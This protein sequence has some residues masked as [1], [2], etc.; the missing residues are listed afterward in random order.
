[1]TD[2]LANFPQR[3]AIG[4]F[5]YGGKRQL[6]QMTPEFFRAF[7]SVILSINGIESGAA[8]D[9]F[10]DVF[11]PYVTEP[12]SVPEMELQR[13]IDIGP[14][15]DVIFQPPSDMPSGVFTI[16][17]A[18]GSTYYASG[19]CGVVVSGGVVS[20]ISHVRG[21]VTTNLGVVSGIFELSDGDGLIITYSVAPTVSVVPR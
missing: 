4:W 17:P 8:S 15:F 11:A 5:E 21:S 20:S 1:M 16:S 10:G 6:V 2:P 14:W 9:Y 7:R 12:E 3:V 19:Q 13:A 18:S